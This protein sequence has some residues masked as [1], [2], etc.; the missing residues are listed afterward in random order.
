M[1]PFSAHHPRP[2][3][4]QLRNGH[5]GRAPASRG[6]GSCCIVPFLSDDHSP[7]SQIV[8]ERYKVRSQTGGPGSGPQ[9]GG[10][11]LGAEGCWPSLVTRLS[12]FCCPCQSHRFTDEEW[13]SET[14][15]CLPVT[16]P[17]RSRTPRASPGPDIAATLPRCGGPPCGVAWLGEGRLGAR[18]WDEVV[19]QVAAEPPG[20]ERGSGVSLGR[21]A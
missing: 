11:E 2:R 19:L 13:D 9:G 16:Q 4:P 3:F 10:D 21:K 17:P 6:H 8:H 12:G 7:L 18:K 1:T 5:V 20:K 14:G 15:K